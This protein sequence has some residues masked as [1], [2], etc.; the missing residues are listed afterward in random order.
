MGNK[1]QLAAIE[2]G[3]VGLGL[4]GSSIVVALFLAGHKVKAIA[5]PACRYETS[6]TKDT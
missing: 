5:P 6:P 4:M 2:V 3:V 1:M